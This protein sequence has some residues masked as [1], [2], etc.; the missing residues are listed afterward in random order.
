MKM[1]IEDAQRDVD[2]GQ[3]DSAREE[4]QKADAY[5]N[6]ILKAGGR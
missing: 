2:A 6:R 4:L 1:A 3:F 5:A